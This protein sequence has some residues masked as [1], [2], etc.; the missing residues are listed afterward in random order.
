MH[1]RPTLGDH[2]R[3]DGGIADPAGGH[4]AAVAVPVLFPTR[5]TAPRYRLAQRPGRL[6]AAGP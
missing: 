5:D 6:P 4:D 2:P 3:I 1:Q